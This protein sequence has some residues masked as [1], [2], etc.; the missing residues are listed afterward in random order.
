MSVLEKLSAAKVDPE[1]GKLKEVTIT[2]NKARGIIAYEV[3]GTEVSQPI[4]FAKIGGSWYMVTPGTNP[5]VKA[6]GPK[7]PPVVVPQIEKE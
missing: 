5:E 2:G 4:E 1:K 7:G 3:N 6:G